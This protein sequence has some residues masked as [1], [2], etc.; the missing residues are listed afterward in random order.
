MVSDR[1]NAW[2]ED[3]VPLAVGHHIC[4]WRKAGTRALDQVNKRFRVAYTSWNSS[5]LIAAVHSGLAVGILPE[6][7]VKAGMRVLTLEDGFPDL[8]SCDVLLIHASG[9]LSPGAQALE[10][11]IMTTLDNIAPRALAAE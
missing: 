9:Q 5:A 8:P 10:Q 6:S 3:V 2:Q 4:E 7:C 11:H 1:H